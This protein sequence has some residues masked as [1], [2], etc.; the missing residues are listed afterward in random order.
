MT[1]T[2]TPPTPNTN[3]DTKGRDRRNNRTRLPRPPGT[4]PNWLRVALGA[5]LAVV[6][7]LGINTYIG[8]ATQANEVLALSNDVARGEIISDGDLIVVQIPNVEGG[9]DA[10]PADGRDSVV[11]QVAAHD[12]LAGTTLTGAAFTSQLTPPAGQSVVGV[13]LSQAQMPGQPLVAGDAVRLVEISPTGGTVSIEA[14]PT[15]PAEVLAVQVAGSGITIVDLL[16]D[17][18]AAADVATR[19]ASGRLA[20][21]IDASGAG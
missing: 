12:L 20:L 2:V 7:A 13:A 18:D 10:I 17:S 21:I 4:R 19:A 1:A 11:G 6:V 8:S 16:V 14:P 3:T 5:A 9:L 15:Y